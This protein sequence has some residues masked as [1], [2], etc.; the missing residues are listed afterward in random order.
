MNEQLFS[1]YR[2]RESSQLFRPSRGERLTVYLWK[3]WAPQ[4]PLV[5]ALNFIAYARRISD[6]Y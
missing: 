5:P 2:E 4:F 1:C 6:Q 3:S